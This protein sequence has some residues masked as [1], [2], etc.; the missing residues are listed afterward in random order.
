M[1]NIGADRNRERESIRKILLKT[2]ALKNT[3]ALIANQTLKIN[4][5]YAQMIQDYFDAEIIIN[6]NPT[7]FII[8]GSTLIEHI[9][10]KSNDDE[11][12]VLLLDAAFFHGIWLHQFDITDTRSATFYGANYVSYDNV[13]FMRLKAPIAVVPL[14]EIDAAMIE[15][16][17]KEQRYAL[18]I[19]LPSRIND[20]LSLIRRAINPWYIETSIRRMDVYGKIMIE[21][22][23]FGIEAE[24]DLRGTLERMGIRDIFQQKMSNLSSRIT[25]QENIFVTDIKHK[26]R[27]EFGENGIGPVDS[28]F[29]A[30]HRKSKTKSKFNNVSKNAAL[31]FDHPFLYFIRHT[32]TGTILLIGE[33]HGF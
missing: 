16:P 30:K 19:I 33:I 21:L 11:A 13:P 28:M 20:D 15:L 18:Y 25:Y 22:P 29:T 7:D 4:L 5:D 14:D 9:P 2:S 8:N 23:T 26:V 31:A 27:M 32:R 10:D 12:A 6:Q 3:R 17:F 1:A 24:Y